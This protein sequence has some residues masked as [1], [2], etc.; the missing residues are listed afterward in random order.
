[1]KTVDYNSPQISPVF[2]TTKTVHNNSPLFFL[3]FIKRSQ[4]QQPATLACLRKM[5]TV[6]YNSPQ[7][8]P[9]FST[10]KTFH[11]NNPPLFLIDVPR[12]F[13]IFIVTNKRT[14]NITRVSLHI[15]Y[16]PTRFDISMSSS[17]SFTSASC[18][19][20]IPTPTQHTPDQ[21]INNVNKG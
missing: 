17:G 21:H 10:M 19:N 9:V 7:I 5:K 14:I 20:P 11:N 6:D 3:V 4:L 8:S 12:I 16:T 13:I 2:N 15:I 18:H 1:M